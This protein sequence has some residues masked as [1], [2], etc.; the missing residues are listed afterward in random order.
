MSEPPEAKPGPAPTA[1]AGALLRAAREATGLHIAALAVSLK[2]PVRKIE[3][4][5]ADRWDELTDSVFVR[6]LAGSACRALRVDPRPILALLPAPA[7]TRLPASASLATDF[8]QRSVSP[9]THWMRP[10]ANPTVL[11]VLALL[12]AAL[13]VYFWPGAP[14]A[15]PSGEATKPMLAKSSPAPFAQ[16]G[17]TAA[18][19]TVADA[20]QVADSGAAPPLLSQMTASVAPV[21]TGQPGA[22]APSIAQAPG[23]PG[24][25]PIISFKAKDN[26]WVEVVDARQTVLMRRIVNAG[27]S[28][29]AAG[30]LPLAVVIGRADAIEVLVRGQSFDALAKSRDN[31]AR[32]EVR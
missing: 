31:V 5:E 10:L 29:S 24:A 16:S 8:S 15:A 20:V 11:A 23:D 27:E 19:G 9:A 32:F 12:V 26:S 30:E 21:A 3:A 1:S 7:Q 14:G 18:P 6:A 28:A 25:V 22:K 17:S 13:L 4:L 2:M